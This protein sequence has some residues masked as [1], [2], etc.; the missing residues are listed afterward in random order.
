[1]P[2]PVPRV[3][4]SWNIIHHTALICKTSGGIGWE[5]GAGRQARTHP[6]GVFRRPPRG[7]EGGWLPAVPGGLL[8]GAHDGLLLR[9]GDV[10]RRGDLRHGAAGGERVRGQ[11]QGRPGAGQR[12]R[13]AGHGKRVDLPGVCHPGDAKHGQ[14][15][16][17][18]YQRRRD[19]RRPP[20]ALPR[21][22]RGLTGHR[23]EP[24]ERLARGRNTLN[25][26]EGGPPVALTARGMLL[27]AL[28]PRVVLIIWT[29]SRPP[30]LARYS[31]A[32][33]AAIR[34]GYSR[35]LPL[36]SAATP[37]DTVTCTLSPPDAP[38][39]IMLS[40][41][42]VARTRSAIR[43]AS[44][45]RVCGSSSENSSPPNRPARS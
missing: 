33:A 42:M 2:G 36:S 29:W 17:V 20:G 37:I 10:G 30:A 13:R 15:V 38:G 9:E 5:H 27:T 22:H 26:S 31:A 4:P 44:T 39:A 12:R 7:A 43:K 40:P 18:P 6:A 3:A 25:V 45:A 16:A 23:H 1:M 34:S 41:A 32:S 28:R 35:W 8:R 14:R 24:A 19:P 21:D 11:D